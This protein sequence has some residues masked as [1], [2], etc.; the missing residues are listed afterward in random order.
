MTGAIIWGLVVLLLGVPFVLFWWRIADRWATKEHKRFRDREGGAAPT[1]VR[2]TEVER[3]G[4]AEKPD[5][6]ADPTN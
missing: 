1:V 4:A 6:G 2:R 5:P 3:G